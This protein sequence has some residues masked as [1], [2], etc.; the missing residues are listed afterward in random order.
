MPSIHYILMSLFFRLEKCVKF[1]FTL[2]EQYGQQQDW[3]VSLVC[4]S[5]GVF[6]VNLKGELSGVHFTKFKG[7][8]QI[9]RCDIHRWRLI[10]YPVNDLMYIFSLVLIRKVVTQVFFDDVISI[11][12]MLMEVIEAE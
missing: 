9:S 7:D 2:L 1:S 3:S 11:V 12:M 4:I 5:R 8:L 6:Q 10:D